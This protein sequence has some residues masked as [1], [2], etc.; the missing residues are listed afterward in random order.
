MFPTKFE[1]YKLTDYEEL[2]LLTMLLLLDEEA[3]VAKESDSLSS[4]LNKGHSESYS[5]L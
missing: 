2:P 4:T 5:L 1:L 3:L